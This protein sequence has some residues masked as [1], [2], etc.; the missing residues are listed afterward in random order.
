MEDLGGLQAA[1]VEYSNMIGLPTLGDMMFTTPIAFV[2]L[3][4]ISSVLLLMTIQI[5]RLLYS[6]YVEDSSSTNSKRLG[7][8]YIIVLMLAVVGT[9]LMILLKFNDDIVTL[10]NYLSIVWVGHKLYIPSFLASL[11]YIYTMR[12]I[13]EGLEGH[14]L[15][16]EAL[17][18]EHKNVEKLLMHV[19]SLKEQGTDLMEDIDQEVH[20]PSILDRVKRL[21][22][23]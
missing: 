6:V 9:T 5:P 11:S 15:L 1:A 8:V 23:K 7:V 19:T 20:C 12:H 2:S 17:R 4:L 10:D 16:V 3:V 21:V 14:K 18:A 22:T 13:H